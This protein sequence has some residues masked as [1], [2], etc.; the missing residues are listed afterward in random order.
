M[1][2]K[3][4]TGQEFEIEFA[5]AWL[6]YVEGGKV[7]PDPRTN[8]QSWNRYDTWRNESGMPKLVSDP[9][10][11]YRWKPAPK[12]MVTIGYQNALKCWC[13]KE[14][15]APEVEAPA[16]GTPIYLLGKTPEVEWED[17]PWLVSWL[18]AGLVFLTREDAQAMS[19]WLATCRKG[20]Q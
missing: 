1:S 18:K 3:E 12:R 10:F 5:R 2:N 7:G 16:M 9:D 17:R 4:Y 8:Y 6:A 19:D 11:A 13:T 20:G 15:V 14:L